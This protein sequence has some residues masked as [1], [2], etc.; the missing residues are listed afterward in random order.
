MAR[1]YPSYLPQG[2]KSPGETEIFR[3]LQDDPLTDQWSVFYS[4]DIASHV[5]QVA[6][7]IDFVLV[8]PSKGVLCLEVKAARS[9]RRVDGAWHYGQNLAPDLRGPFKQ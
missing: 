6:G 7:E 2:V 3:R 5:R 1:M 4:L 9:I 8:V